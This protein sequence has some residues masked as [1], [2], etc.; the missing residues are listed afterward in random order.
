LGIGHILRKTRSNEAE[1]IVILKKLHIRIYEA[2]PVGKEAG[3]VKL[4]PHIH[5][6]FYCCTVHVAITVVL[7]QLMHLH[8]LK[9]KF[10]SIFN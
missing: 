2:L 10:T 1:I 7:F 5:P 3:G 8:T 4:T 6:F 9:H